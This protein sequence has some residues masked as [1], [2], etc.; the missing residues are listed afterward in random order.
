MV[1]RFFLLLLF[2]G[3]TQGQ[4]LWG[5]TAPE[6]MQDAQ[7]NLESKNYVRARALFLLAYQGFANQGDYK[8]AIE[9]GAEVTSLYYRENIYDLAFEFCRRM[10]E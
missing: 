6:L 5:Q 10:T 2:V 3:L 1:K 8:Q 9:A 7:N 4:L